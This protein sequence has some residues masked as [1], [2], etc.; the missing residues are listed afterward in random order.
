MSGLQIFARQN[1]AVSVKSVNKR[2]LENHS[3]CCVHGERRKLS[4]VWIPSGDL[5][6]K[7]LQIISLHLA[8]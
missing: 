7:K 5:Y 4:Q 1:L 3:V 6:W 2:G 8:Q